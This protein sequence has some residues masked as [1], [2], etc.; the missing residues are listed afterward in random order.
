MFM[1]NITTEQVDAIMNIT[2][3]INN[4]KSALPWNNV[5][6][7]IPVNRQVTANKTKYG[8]KIGKRSNK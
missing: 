1:I 7:K 3:N 4:K 8:N 6:I 5:S 2:I